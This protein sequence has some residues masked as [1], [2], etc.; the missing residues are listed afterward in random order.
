MPE[1]QQ[2]DE[3]LKNLKGL[4]LWHAP[5][6]SC[7]QRVR[8]TLVERGRDFESYLINLEKDEHATP[9]YQRIHPKGLVPA[10]VEDGRLYIESIDIIRH[11]AGADS[12]L[13]HVKD[14]TLLKMADQAQLDLKLLSFEFLFRAKPPPPPKAVEAFQKG[15]QNEWL[16]QFRKDFAAGFDVDRLNAAIARTDAGFQHLNDLLSDGRA[17]LEGT[18]FN[19]SDIAWMPNVHRFRLMDWPFERTPHLQAWFERIS[20]R[21][22]YQQALVEWQPKLAIESFIAY[23]EKRQADGTDVRSFPH[24]KKSEG[25]S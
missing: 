8:I 14:E 12:P 18:E 16:Q 7:S 11:I 20:A 3:S 22:S 15:H 10:L 21:P 17:Y 1:I 24:F 25:Q 23:T 13:A 4:H 9:E 5:M 2:K 6:S 19:L